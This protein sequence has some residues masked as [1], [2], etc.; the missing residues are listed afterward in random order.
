M[1][2]TLRSEIDLPTLRISVD[3][4]TSDAVFAVVRGR[5]E[6]TEVAR[7]ALEDLGL[8]RSAV[9]RVDDAALTVPRDVV[10][11]LEHA[12]AGIGE[13]PLPPHNALWLEFPV[14]RGLV[15]V[16]PWERLLRSLERPL[17]RLPFHPVR[18]QKPGARLDVAICS[19][20]PFPTD[21]FEPPQI[22]NDLARQY[23]DSPGRALTVH[24]FTDAEWYAP[25]CDA[26]RPLVD[27]SDVVVHDPT[28]RGLE[29]QRPPGQNATANPWLTWILDGVHGGR[30][31]VVHFAAHGYMSDGRGALAFAE[32]PVRNGGSATF[33]EAVELIEFLTRVGAVGLAL[34]APPGS[35]SGAGLRDLADYVAQSRPGVTAV[36]DVEADPHAEQFGRSLRSLLAPSGRVSP[37]SPAMTAWVH[38]LFVEV[39]SDPGA[40][41]EPLSANLLELTDGLMLKRDGRSAFLQEATR[42]TAA[43]EDDVAWVASASRSIEQLQMSWLPYTVDLPVDQAAV[44]ALNRVASLLEQHVHLAYPTTPQEPGGS[45]PPQDG[46]P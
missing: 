31:D 15:H 39:R 23:L 3:L 13:S 9:G 34:S 27:S 33:V 38:P 7:C 4:A 41:S 44:N 46:P 40:G 8:P 30:L 5:G 18:P 14:S 11:L 36:H 42:E 1:A 35:N 29:A 37:P 28:D 6:P 12:T 45:T 26:V 43:R 25:T 17:F 22:L 16:L 21:R 19:S 24:L 10:A 20:T 2:K 32:S